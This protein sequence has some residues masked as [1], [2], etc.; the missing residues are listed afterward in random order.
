MAAPSNATTQSNSSWLGEFWGGLSN[1]AGNTANVWL[2]YRQDKTKAE[3]DKIQANNT[4]LMG[5]E[6]LAAWEAQQS[7]GNLLLWG[8]FLFVGIVAIIVLKKVLK[9]V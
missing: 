8:V 4:A 6:Q 5:M 7:R 1:I 3:L 2:A 9:K